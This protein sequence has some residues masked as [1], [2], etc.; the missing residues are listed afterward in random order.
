MEPSKPSLNYT[1]LNL[2][3]VK[4]PNKRRTFQPNKPLFNV[5]Q[6]PHRQTH[7]SPPQEAG[8]KRLPAGIYL[9]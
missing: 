3:N 1:H 5:L 9:S 4:D 6:D 8:P 7:L 2:V